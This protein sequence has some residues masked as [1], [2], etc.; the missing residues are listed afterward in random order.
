MSTQ[1]GNWYYINIKEVGFWNSTTFL[2]LH[3]SDTQFL[4]IALG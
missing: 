4:Q 3:F 1:L 2:L